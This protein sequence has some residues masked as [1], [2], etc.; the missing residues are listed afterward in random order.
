MDGY[1]DRQERQLSG[2]TP[3][4]IGAN[5]KTAV[6][7][8]LHEAPPTRPAASYDC[9]SQNTSFG[10]ANPARLVH[11]TRTQQGY[12]RPAGAV[13][14]PS[15]CVFVPVRTAWRTSLY[16]LVHSMDRHD[17]CEPLFR[18]SSGS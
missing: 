11:R 12:V 5:L 2:P 9:L 10:D 14:A 18:P 1:P 3:A 8:S 7:A 4:G 13:V 16:S 17:A 15:S 6:P